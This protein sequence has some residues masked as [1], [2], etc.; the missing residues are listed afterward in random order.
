M[1]PASV[2][3]GQPGVLPYRSGAGEAELDAVVPG[4]VVRRREHRSRR[5]LRPG[6][7]VH[8]IGRRQSEVDDVEPLV[9]HALG[10]RTGQFDPGRA[11]V[12]GHEHTSGRA[13]AGTVVHEATERGTDLLAEGGIELVGH[14][15]PDVIGLEDGVQIRHAAPQASQSTSGR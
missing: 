4:G 11:H 1:R 10:E 3:A 9:L 2:G 8:Q 15:P 5:V 14:N 7:E 6:G 13:G 12:P